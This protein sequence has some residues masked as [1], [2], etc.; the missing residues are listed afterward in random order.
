MLRRA[1][2][3][4]ALALVLLAACTPTGEPPGEGWEPSPLGWRRRVEPAAKPP[5]LQHRHP[6]APTSA[7]ASDPGDPRCGAIEIA[8]VGP[9]LREG[10]RMREVRQGWHPRAE[11]GQ[12]FAIRE[13]RVPFEVPGHTFFQVQVEGAPRAIQPCFVR[14]EGPSEHLGLA[15]CVPSWVLVIEATPE[16][17]P[18]TNDEWAQLLGLLDGATAVYPS[19]AELDRC[20]SGLPSSVR[21]AVPPLGLRLRGA[22]QHAEFVERVDMGDELT[23]LVAVHATLEEGRLELE[24]RELWTMDRE[25]AR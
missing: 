7:G 12:P 17:R 2:T 4:S 14:D 23:M 13:A 1:A 9:W 20:T 25:G 6:G 8:P 16:A 5:P 18:Q 10:V 22:E 21:A 19:E 11:S 3:T 15:A 24:R